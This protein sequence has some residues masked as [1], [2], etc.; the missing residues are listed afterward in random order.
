MQF[1]TEREKCHA[2]AKTVTSLSLRSFRLDPRLFHCGF[3]LDKLSLG[4]AQ[5]V[6]LQFFLSL[7]PYNIRNWQC[8]EITHQKIK[9]RQ[10]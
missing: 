6:V 3:V 4:Q 9:E 2:M 5:Q 1:E 8:Y 10:H 7:M